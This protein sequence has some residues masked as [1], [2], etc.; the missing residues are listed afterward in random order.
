M[1]NYDASTSCAS[2]YSLVPV[3]ANSSVPSD[4][5]TC[6]YVLTT[7]TTTETPTTT[8]TTEAPT[9]TTT[10]STKDDMI[11]ENAQKLSNLYTTLS[12]SNE[13]VNATALMDAISSATVDPSLLN[14]A[15][16]NASVNLMTDL[17]RQ[18]V[19][20]SQNVRKQVF[21]QCAEVVSNVMQSMLNEE[22]PPGAGNVDSASDSDQKI[23]DRE[24]EK[25]KSFIKKVTSVVDRIAYLQIQDA[26]VGT[27]AVIKSSKVTIYSKRTTSELLST[28]TFAVGSSQFQAPDE[29]S[30]NLESYP[31]VD[32]AA[33][34]WNFNLYG[35]LSG[36]KLLSNVLSLELKA[37]ENSIPVR[38][39][40]E[41]ISIEI[42][43][44]GD[45]GLV[46]YGRRI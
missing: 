38:N 33:V 25:K 19:N 41:S 30:K 20:M 23:R 7:T 16:R 26:P 9:T 3:D 29:L 28:E 31:T 34:D 1:C 45:K 46:D 43:L 32:V 5:A 4:P 15:A 2:G 42:K 44:P 13:S 12:L 39:L 11:N 6:T 14:E 21:Q 17:L 8:T 22:K 37:G 35:P 24:K 40:K 18:N 10:P 27:E 36:T